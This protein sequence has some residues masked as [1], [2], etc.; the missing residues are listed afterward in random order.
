MLLAGGGEVLQ[1]LGLF[2]LGTPSRGNHDHAQ[3]KS[4]GG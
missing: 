2:V 4:R 3:T 1:L